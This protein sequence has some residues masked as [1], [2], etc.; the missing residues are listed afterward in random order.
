MLAFSST[1]FILP[2]VTSIQTSFYSCS[3]IL[4]IAP[5][6][7]VMHI[8]FLYYTEVKSP[9]KV[10]QWQLNLY[11]SY[12]KHFFAHCFDSC[13][14]CQY[15]HPTVLSLGWWLQI[16]PVVKQPLWPQSAVPSTALGVRLQG[17]WLWIGLWRA[18]SAH[19][20]CDTHWVKSAALSLH[21][22]IL[23]T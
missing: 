6:C 9:L 19:T 12:L 20:H 7:T 3:L 21:V 13:S 8:Y 16:S 14:R 18:L 10:L 5:L 1:P 15:P 2:E 23:S 4:S 11:T 17:S 22:Y